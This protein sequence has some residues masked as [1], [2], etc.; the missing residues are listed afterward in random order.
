L[1]KTL[2]KVASTSTLIGREGGVSGDRRE[3]L[4]RKRSGGFSGE[5]FMKINVKE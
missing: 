4:V 2:G 1:K 5:G 3:A